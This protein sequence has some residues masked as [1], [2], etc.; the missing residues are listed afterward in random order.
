MPQI[1]HTFLGG[2]SVKRQ[3]EIVS[4]TTTNAFSINEAT[5]LQQHFHREE[6]IC[7]SI[8]VSAYTVLNP[9]AVRMRGSIS[10]VT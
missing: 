6:T 1:K 4:L 5:L 2:N 9:R 10:H 8:A 3:S 7:Y